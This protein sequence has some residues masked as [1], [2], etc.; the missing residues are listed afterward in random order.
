ML[1]WINGPFGG[2]KT[3]TAHEIRRR[4]AGGIVCD[5]ELLGLGLH[6]MTSPPYAETFRIWRLAPGRL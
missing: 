1:L 4:L 3:Q 5:P 2:G 6:R